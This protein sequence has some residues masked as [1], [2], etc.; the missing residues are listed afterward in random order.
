MPRTARFLLV[1]T[2]LLV[3]AASGFYAV[4][5]LSPDRLQRSVEGWLSQRTRSPAEIATL[6]LVLGFPIRLEGTGVRLYDGAVTVES[7]SAR[8]DVISLLLGRPRLNR[9]RLDGAHLRLNRTPEGTWQPAL[10]GPPRPR[11]ETEPAL[12]PLR[13]IETITRALLTRPLLAD[14]LIVRRSR[15]SLT[16]ASASGRAEPVHLVFESVNGRLL[17][18]RLFGDARLFLRVR[19][20]SGGRERGRLEWQGSKDEDGVMRATMAATGL[21]LAALAP[22]ARWSRPGAQLAGTLDGVADYQTAEPGVSRLDLDLAVRRLT[23]S[24]AQRER[25]AEPLSVPELTLRMGVL[26]DRERLA[27]S[28]ARIGIGDL[29]FA[30]DAQ[31]ARPLTESSAARVTLSL[32]ELALNPETAGKLADWLPASARE[33]VVSVA[34]RVR[35]GTLQHVEVRGDAPV[36]RWR[37]VASGGLERL[38]A[39]FDL[40]LG[41]EGVAIDVDE[42]NRLSE[43]RAQV[44]YSGDTLVVSDAAGMLNGGPLPELAGSFAGVSRLLSSLPEGRAVTSSA[45]VLVGFTPLFEVLRG[46]PDPNARRG[47]PPSVD[48]FLEQVQHPALLWPLRDVQVQVVIEPDSDG[49]VIQLER[50]TWAGVLLDGKIDWTLRPTRRLDVE[51]VASALGAEAPAPPPLPDTAQAPPAQPLATS[52]PERSEAAAPAAPARAP[53]RHPW[54]EGR[55]RV[56]PVDSPR[57]GQSAAHGRFAAAGGTVRIQDVEIDLTPGGRLSGWADLDLTHPDHVPYDADVR[58]EGA[59]I[60]TLIAQRGAKGK[61]ATG[62]LGV[63]GRIRGSLVPGSPMLHDADGSLQLNAWD[64]TIER[65][66]PPVFALALAS[67]SLNPFSRRDELR[68]HRAVSELSLE[69]GRLSTDA[70]DIEGPD[71]RLFVSGSLDLS[72]SP[73]EV[74]AELALFLFRQVDRALEL[75]PIVNVLLLG[76]NQN[77]IAAYFQLSGTWEEP[78]VRPKPLRTLEEGPGSVLTKGI[79]RVMLRGMKAFGGLFRGSAKS[80][81][82]DQAPSEEQ[83]PAPEPPAGEPTPEATP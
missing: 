9:L 70:L 74:D 37:R 62:T 12:E 69:N 31:I 73:H 38:P 36:E 53:L 10:F 81:D 77:L 13:A 79:P 67:T 44:S 55:F 8:I 68:Y 16:H 29:D 80:G 4:Q 72:R 71:V 63:V 50:S 40:S 34:E 76:E 30:L 56:G 7:A 17:H 43:L 54:A 39:G 78:N 2:V 82:E 5:A 57:W 49:V 35:A 66:V 42:A 22:Y 64:G 24:L 28:K 1:A 27:F 15:V 48:L 46:E 21:D 23:T 33:R 32:E 52:S 26:L 11:E 60:E 47:P 3:A 65:S 14:S 61:Y 59:D 41:F 6:R 45:E 20:E 25:R 83:I 75:I 58:L 51:L 18:S 19:L